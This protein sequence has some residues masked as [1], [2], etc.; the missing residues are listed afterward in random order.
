MSSRLFQEVR[1]KRGLAYSVGSYT[2]GYADAGQVGVYLGTRGDNLGTACEVIAGEL[3][4]IADRPLAADELQRAKDHLKGRLVLG[5]ESPG[6]RM[7]R[8]GRSLLTGTELL[9]IDEITDRVD[10]V[11]AEDVQELARQHWQ[12]ELLSAAA[13]GP[14]EDVIRAAAE[15]LSPALTA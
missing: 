3:R 8:I 12:P 4:R 5:L 13:I 11:T 2:V 1:E 10:A 7:N 9:S 15:R 6:T 14:S